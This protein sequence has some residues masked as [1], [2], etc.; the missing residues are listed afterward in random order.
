MGG[1]LSCANANWDANIDAS[2]YQ[3]SQHWLFEGFF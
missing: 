1:A 3:T 2:V